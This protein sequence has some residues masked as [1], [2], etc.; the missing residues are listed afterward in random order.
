MS[1]S[2]P[3]KPTTHDIAERAHLL[4]VVFL[5]LGA[6]VPAILDPDLMILRGL[7]AKAGAQPHEDFPMEVGGHERI[8]PGIDKVLTFSMREVLTAASTALPID[9]VR[10]DV[11]AIGMLHGGIRLGD[12]INRGGFLNDTS[13]PLLQF[14]KH[15]RNACAH[16]DRRHFRGPIK[17][18]ATCR[19]LTI[20]DDLHGKRATME[21]VSPRLYVDFLDDIAN[22]FVPGR[23]PP[24]AIGQ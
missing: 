19:G 14:A 7:L 24:P 13:V 16:G 2:A 11:F 12:M 8:R 23:V 1:V 4:K 18:P 15:F 5:A 20:T 22:H 9:V 21:A 3:L 10:D 6:C 17:Y